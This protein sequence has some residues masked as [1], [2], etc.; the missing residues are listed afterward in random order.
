MLAAYFDE[1]YNH[2]TEKTQND[3]LVYTVACCLS[4]VTRWK[5]FEK[6]WRFQLQMAGVE[7]F[8]MKDYESRQGPYHD[9]SNEKRVK[10]LKGLH[11]IMKDHILY[12]CSVTLNKEDFDE[13]IKSTPLLAHHFGKN[14][15][16]FN[17]RLCVKELN[18]WCDRNAYRDD[19]LYVFGE[20]GKQG[21]ALDRMFG[22][23]LRD[24]KLKRRYR[25]KDR[26]VKGIMKE[27]LPLQAADILAYELN[28]RALNEAGGGAQVVR[29]SLDNLHLSKWFR[30]AYFARENLTNLIV[31]SFTKGPAWRDF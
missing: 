24:P 31:D 11:K 4:T 5:K 8:H 17:V 27:V 28:K 7:S 9:W 12:G 1:S 15:Y 22:E 14:Y 26:W 25:T 3:P 10:V 16:D 6:R 18:E 21:S 2:R 29:K 30:N 13:K 20:E 19:M 23:V